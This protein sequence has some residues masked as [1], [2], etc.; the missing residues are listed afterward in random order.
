MSRWKTTYFTALA[1][2]VAAAAPAAADQTKVK[3]TVTSPAA[4][5]APYYIAI[6]K[7]YFAAEGLEVE[8][9]AAGGGVAIPAMISGS[10]DFSMS[11][12]V[13]ISA[14]MRGA[15]LRVIYTMADRPPYQLWATQPELKTLADL[16]GKQVGIIS[17]GDTFEIAMRITLRDAGLPGDWVGFTALG[18]GA[19]PRQA[20]LASGSLPAVILST[21]DAAPFKGTHVL[22]KAHVV[23]DMEQSIRMP[24]TGVATTLRHLTDDPA[25]VKHFLRAV[26]KALRYERAY[27]DKTVDI[28]MKA[29]PTNSRTALGADWDDL[30][31]TLTADG[32]APDA[33]VRKDLEIRAALINVP[34]D[35]IG[36]P[37]RFYDYGP[38]RAVEAE[39]NASGWKPTP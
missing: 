28:V 6:D 5:S 13:S 18:P 20:A 31:P 39:L 2:S 21:G 8:I 9:V 1:L 17:R 29:D 34:A 38:L 36:P 10:V 33:L 25:L 32:T 22:D 15:A 30:M 12:A 16:K 11:A 14:I 7:G 37:S 35:K 19:S 24:Y 27:R 23:V 4:T 3:M 26:V